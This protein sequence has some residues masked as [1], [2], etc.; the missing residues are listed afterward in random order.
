MNILTAA[1]T[2]SDMWSGYPADTARA[3]S[4]DGWTRIYAELMGEV[5][6]YWQPIGYPAGGFLNPNP[7]LSYTESVAEGVDEG[8]R[9]LDGLP[10]PY[11]LVGYSQGGEVVCRLANRMLEAGRPPR[12]VVTFGSPCRAPG[13]TL[14]GNNPVGSGIS[15][16][17][18]DPSLTVVD[19]VRNRGEMYGNAPDDTY[20]PDFYRLF[21]AAQL[22]VSFLGAIIR[23]LIDLLGPERT[24]GLTELGADVP[25]RSVVPV[26]RELSISKAIRS[27]ALVIEFAVT[28]AH[29][30]YHLPAPEFG[31]R[32]GVDIAIQAL[33]QGASR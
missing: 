20:L 29:T 19:I 17:Y 2:W 24:A 18:A 15:R 26:P 7:N 1:G 25:E 21:T 3:V 27:V 16:Y 14:V 12:R 6:A 28:Q 30:S 22:D 23:F 33:T 5:S 11:D 13:P 10:G 8:A 31:G 32:T 4:G 9:L